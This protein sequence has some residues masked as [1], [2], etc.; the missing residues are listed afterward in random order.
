LDNKEGTVYNS[1]IGFIDKKELYDKL[2]P[3]STELD[4]W[5]DSSLTGPSSRRVVRLGQW[6]F[7]WNCADFEAIVKKWLTPEAS[8]DVLV[9]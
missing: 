2:E 4:T 5:L 7:R 9:C 6:A 3:S 8:I 1:G